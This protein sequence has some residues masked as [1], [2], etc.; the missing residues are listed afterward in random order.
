[1]NGI[2]IQLEPAEQIALQHHAEAL[3]VD[4]DDIAY[5][6]LLHLMKEM[7]THPQPINQEILEARDARHYQLTGWSGWNRTAHPFGDFGDDYSVPGM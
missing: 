6:A 3:G 5:A 7:K 4:P 2:S 1:M